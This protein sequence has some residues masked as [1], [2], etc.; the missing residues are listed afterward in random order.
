[1]KNLRPAVAEVSFFGRRS[2]PHISQALNMEPAGIGTVSSP[3]GSEWLPGLQRASPSTPLDARAMWSSIIRM[4]A[5]NQRC[6]ALGCAGLGETVGALEA[7]VHH[8]REVRRVHLLR[9]AGAGRRLRP[10]RP[11]R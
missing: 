6:R 9:E 8:R 1:M 5:A 7:R 4:L 3:R 10:D 11:P 2:L